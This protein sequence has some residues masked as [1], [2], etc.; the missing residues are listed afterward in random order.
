LT[1]RTTSALA[2]LGFGCLVALGVGEATVRLFRLQGDQFFVPDPWL[3]WVHRPGFRGTYVSKDAVHEDV[4]VNERGLL[5]PAHPDAKPP[6]TRRILLLGDSYTESM[7][8][9]FEETWGDRLDEALGDGWSVINGGVAAYGIDNT[10]LALRREYSRYDVDAYFLLFF[11]GN[12]VS[13][14][15]WELYGPDRGGRPKPWFTTD[16]A[17]TLELHG[18]PMPIASG[19][20]GRLKHELRQ[21]SHLY[22]FVKDRLGPVRVRR[23]YLE[24]SAHRIPRPWYVYGTEPREDFTRAWRTTAALVRAIRVEAE[25]AGVV[26]AAGILP[27]DWRVEPD[28]L[29]EVL[30]TYPAMADTS[31]WDFASP[32]RKAEALFAAEGIPCVDLTPV[33]LEA[34]RTSDVPLYSDHLTPAGHRV[35]ADRLAAFFHDVVIPR[36][37]A[38]TSATAAAPADSGQG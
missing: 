9:P 15:D 5:G 27:T 13:D 18:S 31:A 7:Q 17:G 8:V 36:I 19:P 37:E 34:R 2:A 16:G 28:Q 3:G 29:A 14:N 12:D 4:R 35:V 24:G 30:A 20:V 23:Q 38:A 11:T 10:L 6:G 1:R 33:L 21:R 25:S 32:D 26:L 22:R